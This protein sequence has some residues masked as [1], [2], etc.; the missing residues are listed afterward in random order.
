MGCIQSCFG[1]EQI[2]DQYRY[3][4]NPSNVL[5]MLH[6]DYTGLI[7][8]LYD[9]FSFKALLT[10]GREKRVVRCGLDGCKKIHFD[11]KNLAKNYFLYLI[12]GNFYNDFILG[13]IQI[14][15]LLNR[16]T[17]KRG[18]QEFKFHITRFDQDLF[19]VKVYNLGSSNTALSHNFTSF[20]EQILRFISSE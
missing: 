20:N 4:N 11:K 17:T 19:M 8:D 14:S 15:N 12:T 3:L 10:V 13:Q 2:D 1:Y 7:I 16:S 18:P 5:D 9:E 6:Q